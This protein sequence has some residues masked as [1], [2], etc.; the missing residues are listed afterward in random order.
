MSQTTRNQSI[1]FQNTILG[2]AKVRYTGF[3]N[4]LSSSTIPSQIHIYRFYG[5]YFCLLLPFPQVNS[6]SANTLFLLRS[7]SFSLHSALEK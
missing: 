3:D 4:T 5:V 6:A 1:C 2:M 7:A